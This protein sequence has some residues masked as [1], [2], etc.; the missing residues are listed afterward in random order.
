[1]SQVF[2]APHQSWKEEQ[3]SEGKEDLRSS[4]E[5]RAIKENVSDELTLKDVRTF[6]YSGRGHWIRVRGVHEKGRSVAKHEE[7]EAG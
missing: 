4:W 3:V 7:C 1:M 2:R 6:L 5:A